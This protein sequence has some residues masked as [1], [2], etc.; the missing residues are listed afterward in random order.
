MASMSTP[1]SASRALPFLIQS[2]LRRRT[3]TYGELGQRINRH[4]RD[5]AEVLRYIRD[6]VC[7]PR[8]LPPL[9]AIVVSKQSGLPGGG[10]LAGGASHL[11]DEEYR[12]KAA[13][14]Q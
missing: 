13:E 7:A 8:G 3:V 6:D 14:L 5:L 1:E 12:Q 2:A 10:F 11:T 9:S 4:P